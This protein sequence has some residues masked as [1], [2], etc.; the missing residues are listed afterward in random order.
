MIAEI[1][2]KATAYPDW[3]IFEGVREIYQNMKDG[4]IDGYP[5][6]IRANDSS[7]TFINAGAVLPREAL[8]IGHTTKED[9][10]DQ[11]GQFGE[12]LKLGS[13]AL[14]RAGRKVTIEFNGERWI[15]KII[16]SQTYDAE[17]LAFYI[18]K[19]EEDHDKLSVKIELYSNEWEEMKRKFLDVVNVEK[20]S[21]SYGSVIMNPDYAGKIFVKGIWVHDVDDLKYGYD[22]NNVKVDR[23]RRMMDR[24]DRGDA[25]CSV[26][27][28]ILDKYED[29]Y[30]AFLKL[31][32]DGAEDVEHFKHS[33]FQLA[34][35]IRKRVV[36][37]FHKEYGDGHPVL[38]DLDAKEIGHF[39]GRGIVV[40][41][42]ALANIIWREVGYTDDF[43][44]RLSSSAIR[45]YTFTE[46]EPNEKRNLLKAIGMVSAATGNR[47]LRSE[48]D[49]VDFSGDV[50][51]Q[52]K[53]D[54]FLLSR[55]TLSNFISCL[56]VL[57]HEVAHCKG[58][59]GDKLHITEVETIWAKIIE[60]RIGG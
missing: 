52:Y 8:L 9:R 28:T 24:W 4:D 30:P 18:Y 60:Q 48:V 22:F 35:E 50:G 49:V 34:N 12:G 21:C 16:K 33:S 27:G 44:K 56:T 59:D 5:M 53:D 57:V 54:R 41:S 11:A 14:V 23:D 7:V 2:L 39:G 32:F 10:N 51:G 45:T 40:Q 36:D 19:T 58:D 13:L 29:A 15:P 38:N 46:L 43:L 20:M 6:E 55:N 42:K 17:V 3:G 1:S 25:L 26:W 37:D 47:S 31:L